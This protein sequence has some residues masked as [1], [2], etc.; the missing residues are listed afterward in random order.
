MLDADAVHRLEQLTHSVRE[1]FATCRD[2]DALFTTA[3]RW[4]HTQRVCTYGKQLA[5]AEGANVEWVLAGCL[6]HDIAHFEDDRIHD[7][8]RLGARISRSI[9]DRVGYEPEAIDTI[10]HAIAAHV[11][12]KADDGLPDTVETQVVTDADNI[13]RFNTYRLLQWGSPFVADFARLCG[14]AARR[15]ERLTQYREKGPLETRTGNELFLRQLD[16]Q[17]AF[18]RGLLEDQDATLLPWRA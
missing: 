10:C 2:R 9:L 15:L 7:H 14:E 17:I 4:E 6:L 5:L 12:G 11:D 18:F 1:H 13:D 8:G 3:Y 16:R